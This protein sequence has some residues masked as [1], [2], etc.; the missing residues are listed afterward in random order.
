MVMSIDLSSLETL[1]KVAGVAGIGIGAFLW[2]ARDLIA[3]NIFP[4]LSKVHAY[5]II[6]LI[7]LLAFIIALAGIAAWVY[8]KKNSNESEIVWPSTSVMPVLDHYLTLS[9]N[10]DFDGAWSAM[11]NIVKKR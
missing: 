2:I 7:I 10:N 4:T 5:R 1:G 11:A 9:D 8:V 6:R 3:K